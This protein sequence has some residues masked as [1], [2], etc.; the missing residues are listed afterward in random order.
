VFLDLGSGKG[1]V[2]L[3]A[4][5]YPFSRIIGLELSP[6]LNSIA[7]SNV[8]ACRSRLRCKNIQLVTGD[9]VDYEVPDHV[10]VVYM[11]NP[12]HGELFRIALQK[13]IQSF[14]RS[15]RRMRLIC[16]AA[17][18]H[19]VLIDTGKGLDKCASHRAC[20]RAVDGRQKWLSGC[21]RS[22]TVRMWDA[23]LVRIRH[24]ISGAE[25]ASIVQLAYR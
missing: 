7:R 1:R 9:V 10:T 3:A 4:A 6:D 22:K 21:T 2:V 20:V 25:E 14:D 15:P 5:L 24:T 11:N 18:E 16:R 19:R 12:F 8:E 17:F 13:V 23:T